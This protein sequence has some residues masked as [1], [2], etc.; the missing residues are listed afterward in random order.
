MPSC[1]L[2]P[3]SKGERWCAAAPPS[4]PS[5]GSSDSTIGPGAQILDHCFLR[6]CV[7]EAGASV[8]PFTHIRP[9][10]RIGAGARVG[11]FVELKKTHLGDGAKAPHLSY[12]G[13]ATIGAKA[14]VGAGTITC[15]Y[16]GVQQARNPHRRGSLHRQRHHPR[17][18][19]HHRRGRLHRRG[20]RDHGGRAAP[21]AR[22]GPGPPG[23]EARLGREMARAAEE[24]VSVPGLGRETR[25]PRHVRNRRLRRNARC[26]PGHPRGAAAARVPRLRLGRGG[27]RARTGV[28]LRRRAAGKLKNLEDSLKAEPLHGSYGVGHTRWA[29]HGRPTE[30]NAHPHVDDQG[31]IVVVHNGI[32]ENYL[33][34]KARLEAAGHRFVHP[35]RHRGGGAPRGPP[36]PRLAR[37]RGPARRSARSRGSTPSCSSTRTSRR[38]SW[39][40][41][42]GP[43]WWWGSARA[44]TSWPP[45]SH[46]APPLHPRFPL[47]GRRGRGDGH[48]RAR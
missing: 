25:E 29:T 36:L 20:Q 21:C 41:G 46:G 31:R 6:D 35:D 40:R 14:N 17:G 47:P 30:E 28:L 18:P 13:D 45:T 22:P 19:H 15:N 43:R 11:N 42:S 37:G 9:E 7:V 26:G 2:S 1:G 32:I 48:P 27:G 8:G 10:S 5:R 12:L 34:L 24:G 16:D 3:C 23:D 38:R 39:E 33:D 44:S 4:G